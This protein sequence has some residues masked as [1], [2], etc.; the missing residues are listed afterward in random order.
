[1]LLLVSFQ[2]KTQTVESSSVIDKSSLQFEIESL[3]TVHNEG[4]IKTES[5]SVPSTLFRFGLLNGLELQL[6][7]PIIKEKIWENDHLIRS[8][9]IFDDIQ[10]GF[11]IDLWKENKL[12]PETSL[13]VRTIIP[14]DKKFKFDNMGKIVSLNLSNT[15]SDKLSLTYNIGYTHETDNSKY[16]FYIVNICYEATPKI[17]LFLENF[18][19]VHANSIKYHSINFGGGYNFTDNLIIDL[20]AGKSINSSTYYFGGIFTFKTKTKKN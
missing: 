15:L 8:L 2:G 12:I 19:D 11:S 18:G 1:M 9:N 6:N 3:Y 13:M 14:T 4:S 5:W 7:T 20:S 17:H 10:V 16:G